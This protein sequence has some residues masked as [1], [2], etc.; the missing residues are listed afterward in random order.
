V[1]CYGSG[2]IVALATYLKRVNDMRYCMLNFQ[3]GH[4][5]KRK[6][7]LLV[8]W[9]GGPKL[10]Q[11][12]LISMFKHKK[13]IEDILETSKSLTISSSTRL[14]RSMILSQLAREGLLSE[15]LIRVVIKLGDEKKRK[16][17]KEQKKEKRKEMKKERKNMT[18]K[19]N[20]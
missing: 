1:E 4:I 18:Q 13:A 16:R 8:L 6:K 17:K 20:I 3:Y 10:E 15:I 12:G 7:L 5:V 2:G 11:S 19:M 9:V 14:K